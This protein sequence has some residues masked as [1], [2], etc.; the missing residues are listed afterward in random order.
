MST[1][2]SF[3]TLLSH[4]LNVWKQP[5]DALHIFLLL[6]RLMIETTQIIKKKCILIIRFSL[7]CTV[8]LSYYSFHQPIDH[9]KITY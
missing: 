4:Y 6:R 8:N 2:L 7:I 5:Y 1:H 9:I 3:Y